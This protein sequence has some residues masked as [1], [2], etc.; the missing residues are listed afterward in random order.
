MKIKKG[1]QISSDDPYYDLSDGGYL[2]PG[3]ICENVEDARKVEEA[4]RILK[5]FLDS[6]EEQI[7]NFLQ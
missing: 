3:D 5:D 4:V 2:I 7:E 1:L 6:C